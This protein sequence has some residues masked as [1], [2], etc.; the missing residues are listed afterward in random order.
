MQV[1]GLIELDRR[2]RLVF[3]RGANFFCNTKLFKSNIVVCNAVNSQ[4]MVPIKVPRLLDAID[5]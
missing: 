1:V 3:V 2:R 4:V 5:V